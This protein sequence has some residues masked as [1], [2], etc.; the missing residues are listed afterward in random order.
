MMGGKSV[1]GK[2]KG[3][4]VEIEREAGDPFQQMDAD[5]YRMFCEQFEQ[6]RLL[7]DAQDYMQTLDEMNGEPF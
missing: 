4:I 2:M 7:E 5:E 1:M 6:D 3:T